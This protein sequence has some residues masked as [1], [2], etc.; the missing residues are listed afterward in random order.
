M[1]LASAIAGCGWAPRTG[2]PKPQDVRRGAG[3]YVDALQER[4]DAGRFES[5]DSLARAILAV[6]PDHPRADEVLY[7]ASRANHALES[8]PRTVAYAEELAR[9]YPLSPRREEAMLLAADAHRSLHRYYE[10]AEIL[11]RLIASPLDPQVERRSIAELRRLAEEKLSAAELDR[12]VRAFPSS[13]LA[14][15]VS[16]KLARAE[17]ARGDYERSYALLADL[18]REFPEH[19]GEREIRYLLEVSATR[20]QDP[21]RRPVHVEAN[22]VGVLLPYTGEY[23]RFGRSFEEGVRLALDEFNAEAEAPVTCVLGDSKADPITALTAVRKL[24]VDSGVVAVIGSV[25]TVPSI[26]A[27]AECNAWKV[28]MVSPLV[29][30]AGFGRIGPWVFQMQV[31]VEVELAA[32]ARLAVKDLLLERIAVLAPS[33]SDARERARFFAGE[34]RRLGGKVVVEEFFGAGVTDFREQIGSIRVKAP[35]AMFIP[36]GPDEL[37]NILP[38]LR[39]YDVQVQ[40]LGLSSWN[41]EKL[42]SLAGRELEGAVFPRQGYYGKDPEAYGRF[43][44]RYS[45][46]H[47]GDRSPSD[48]ESVSPIAAAGYFGTRFVL[49]AIAGGAVDREQIKEHLDGVL[50]PGAELRLKEVES[51]PL[52]KVDSGRARD[53]TPPK[54]G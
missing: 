29:R 53:F 30:E 17:F 7:I 9:R 25:F 14:A 28:P 19:A 31:P 35:D 20:M 18:L 33:T 21:S 37:V 54:R 39:F 42:L 27:A 16:F 34:I 47:A 13:P 22:T 41:S 36:A 15:E 4:L 23:S 51:L 26:V 49:D 3:A 24:I 46:A 43:A 6:D 11:S 8:W 10:S 45:A 38:Q 2:G 12:L 48:L 50:N 52:L 44:A 5:A 40:L 32:M 1:F